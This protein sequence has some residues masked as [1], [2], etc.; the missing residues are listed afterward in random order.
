MTIEQPRVV[1]FISVDPSKNKVILSISDHL[2]WNAIDE[3]LVLLQEKINSYLSFIESGDLV[4]SYPKAKGLA[5]VI[6]VVCKY[7]LNQRAMDFF[8]N[9]AMIVDGAGFQ[10]SYRIVAE[11]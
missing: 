4:E 3:H 10:L 7:P 9:A 11:D 6:D 5:V 1:D 2:D 8:R